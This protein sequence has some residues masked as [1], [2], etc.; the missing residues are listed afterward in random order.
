MV[1]ADLKK[2]DGLVGKIFG[3]LLINVIPLAGLGFVG[4]KMYRGEFSLDQL[5]EGAGR[6][7]LCL[8]VALGLLILVASGLLPVSHAPG[9]ELTS[10][11]AGIAGNPQ[12]VGF[13][14]TALGMAPLA[15][16]T[17]FLPVVCTESLHL[18]RGVHGSDLADDFLHGALC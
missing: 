5:P 12:G 17:V 10:F 14:A 3:F 18:D 9:P 7:G 13:F 16:P 2:K 8:G 6:T 1:R 4:W 15:L 11:F